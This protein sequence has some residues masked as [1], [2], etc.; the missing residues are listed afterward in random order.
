MRKPR[1]AP[2]FLHF[3]P[4]LA[5]PPTQ[6]TR[7]RFRACRA[8][9]RGCGNNPVLG[10]PK[11]FARLLD[12]PKAY[13]FGKFVDLAHKLKPAQSALLYMVVLLCADPLPILLLMSV[14]AP[15]AR[16]SV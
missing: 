8:D 5:A 2:G 13:H 11:H 14:K 15:R 16:L 9:E 10:S 1:I 6:S 7:P 12:G 3:C 4:S